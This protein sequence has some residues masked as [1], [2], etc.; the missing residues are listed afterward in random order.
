[1]CQEAILCFEAIRCFKAVLCSKIN[2]K[3]T[4]L[5]L[6]GRMGGVELLAHHREYRVS[7]F[8]TKYYELPLC[9]SFLAWISVR[10]KSR[11][12]SWARQYFPEMVD[13]SSEEHSSE[14]HS[15]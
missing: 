9:V 13:C 11:L 12:A 7:S 10:F 5:I 3:K 6:V 14:E 1:M 8:V 2:L 15:S 4:K